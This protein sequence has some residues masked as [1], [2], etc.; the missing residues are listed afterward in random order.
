M[1]RTSIFNAMD[2]LFDSA[3]PIVN[4]KAEVRSIDGGFAVDILLPGFTKEE[5][6]IQVEGEDLIIEAKTDRK[7][8]GFL[9]T[10]VKRTYVAHDI[11]SDSIKAVLENGLLNVEFTTAKKKSAKTV[12][13][14]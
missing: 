3:Y 7:L 10:H 13:I 9:N 11:D 2:E 5:V 12:K 14:L 1:Y 8:P 6:D 4:N